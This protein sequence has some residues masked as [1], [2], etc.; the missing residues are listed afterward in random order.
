MQDTQETQAQSLGGDDPL[1]KEVAFTPVFLT[2]KFHG[3]R[4]LV[5]YS[6]WDHKRDGHNLA[7]K[8]QNILQIQMKKADVSGKMKETI[9]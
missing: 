8:Q 3:Q 4:S 1:E 5:G 7:I 9:G 6:P 2:G